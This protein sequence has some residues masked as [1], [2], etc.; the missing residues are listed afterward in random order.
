[1]LKILHTADWH[2]GRSFGMFRREDADKLARDRV[3]FVRSSGSGC[4]SYGSDL[5][6]TSL[7]SS[8]L[9]ILGHYDPRDRPQIYP[10]P[11]FDFDGAQTVFSEG[12][13]Y[14]D[15]DRGWTSI[16]VDRVS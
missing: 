1:M 10:G 7:D 6:V 9:H 5:V 3:M 16:F 11:S 8:A 13:L 15:P 2:V 14:R 4:S 12:V